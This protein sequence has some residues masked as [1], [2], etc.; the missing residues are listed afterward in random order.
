M[1]INHLFCLQAEVLRK[2]PVIQNEADRLNAKPDISTEDRQ[3]I[4]QERYDSGCQAQ[5]S[6]LSKLC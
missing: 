5:A 2:V 4:L 1:G 3:R 6:K